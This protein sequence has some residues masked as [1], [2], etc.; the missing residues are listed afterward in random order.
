M[1]VRGKSE[2]DTAYQRDARVTLQKFKFNTLLMDM[3]RS[4]WSSRKVL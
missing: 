2:G 3:V 4:N 1:I